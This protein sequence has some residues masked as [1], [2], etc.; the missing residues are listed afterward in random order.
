MLMRAARRRSG[1]HVMSGGLCLGDGV[2]PVLDHQE[3]AVIEGM[4]PAG[5]IPCDENIIGD[6]PIGIEGP[7]RGVAHHATP[8]GG[9]LCGN[10]ECLETA[11]FDASAIPWDELAFRST[12]EGLR[13]YLA[14]LLH[15]LQRE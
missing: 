1:Q 8:I 11:E 7:T 15:P 3:L 5:D 13:D 2:A 9:Q 6:H 14:G 12:H 10:D 4:R